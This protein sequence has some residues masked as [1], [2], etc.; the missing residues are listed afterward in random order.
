[1]KYQVFES[2]KPADCHHCDI[3][4]SWNKSIFDTFEEAKDYAVKWFGAFLPIQKD[5]I[6]PNKKYDYLEIREILEENES[7][8]RKLKPISENEMRVLELCIPE[9]L[10]IANDYNLAEIVGCLL[11]SIQSYKVENKELSQKIKNKYD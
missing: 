1:M 6:L 3:D 10:K 5:L 2:G 9:S 4:K 7:G 8:E 11:V